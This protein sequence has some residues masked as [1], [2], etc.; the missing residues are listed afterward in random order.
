MQATAKFINGTPQ[1][2]F[3]PVFGLVALVG[4]LGACI[5]AAAYVASIGKIGPGPAPFT[6]LP[7]VTWSD[8]IRYAL[9]YQLFGYLWLNAF[10][11]G[12]T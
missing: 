9:L 7:T 1:V 2:F 6:F 10:F 4:L 3:V 8:E 5:V 12:C 11:I